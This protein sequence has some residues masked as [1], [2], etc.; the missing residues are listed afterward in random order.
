MSTPYAANA[1]I[2]AAATLTQSLVVP[3]VDSVVT[4]A[5][6]LD[7]TSMRTGAVIPTRKLEFPTVTAVV[8]A[9]SGHR[10]LDWRISGTGR[11]IVWEDEPVPPFT[12][13]A[14]DVNRSFADAM[15]D[16]ESQRYINNVATLTAP[17]W[18]SQYAG[19]PRWRLAS[20]TLTVAIL[21][22]V[23][24]TNAAVSAEDVFVSDQ[25]LADSLIVRAHRISY[26]SIRARSYAD[27]S[28][29]LV[30]PHSADF[31]SGKI[32]AGKLAEKVGMRARPRGSVPSSGTGNMPITCGAYR[33]EGAGAA[34]RLKA[35]PDM[36]V[37]GIAQHF[38]AMTHLDGESIGSVEFLAPRDAVLI[39]ITASD[40]ALFNAQAQ[41][42]TDRPNVIFPV[43]S[44]VAIATM[45]SEYST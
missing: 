11:P 14:A 29:S 30:Y 38:Q 35:Y 18:S 3:E 33:T 39:S 26:A 7:S 40:R 27:R 28:A 19:S 24:T 45:E 6:A 1:A 25:D 41:P 8:G 32:D 5:S 4:A 31:V 20:I 42:L 37:N 17:N 10:F 23:K 43:R 15:T 9:S 12:R 22:T 13:D 34:S 44:Y 2:G 21:S 36:G 16:Y